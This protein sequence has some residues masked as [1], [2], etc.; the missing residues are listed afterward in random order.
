MATGVRTVTELTREIKGLLEGKESLQGIWVQGEVSNFKLHP[1]GHCYFS[2]RDAQAV[3]RAVM[4]RSRALTLRFRPENGQEVLALGSVGVYERDGLYQLYVDRLE[5]VG[6]GV[7]Y[8]EWLERK[9]RLEAEGLF[10]PERKRP[11]PLLPRRV[12]VVTALGGAALRDILTV[13][14]RR[15]PR[16]DVLVSPAL[17]QGEEAP[18]DLVR[19]LRLLASQGDVDVIILGRGG[20]AA[21]DL[22]AFHDEELVRTVASCPVPVVAAVGHETDFTLVDFAADR[23]APTP[24]AAAEMAVPE[25]A[26]LER[27][28]R[29]LVLRLEQALRRRGER[30]RERLAHLLARPAMARPTARIDQERQRVD[31]LWRALVSAMEGRLTALRQSLGGTAGRLQALSPLAVLARGYAVVTTA[32]GRVLRSVAGVEP[33]ATVTARLLDGSFLARVTE[34]RGREGER[35]P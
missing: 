31:G 6:I 14:R 34:V 21:E 4:F 15:Y 19:A 25:W 20:G 3:I 26:R 18:R 12:G 11:L 30:A 33:G 9:R 13:I 1:S 22:S 17:V 27:E 10:A 32:E 2:L 29:E 8:L 16:M 7:Q 5:P 24:S 28:R 23:R 35:R